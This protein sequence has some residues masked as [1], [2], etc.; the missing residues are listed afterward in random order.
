MHQ[1]VGGH[2][3]PLQKIGQSPFYLISRDLLPR[4]ETRKRAGSRAKNRAWA[5]SRTRTRT[6]SGPRRGRNSRLGFGRILRI[7]WFRPA[8]FRFGRA[9]KWDRRGRGW[10]CGDSGLCDRRDRCRWGRSG[11][12]LDGQSMGRDDFL[13]RSRCRGRTSPRW[14]LRWLHALDI[15]NRFHGH[16]S[17]HQDNDSDRKR[18]ERPAAAALPSNHDGTARR[19]RGIILKISVT[20]DRHVFR[21]FKRFGVRTHIH[22]EKFSVDEQKSFCVSE[23]G[24]LGEILVFDFLKTAGTDLGHA[25]GL[26]EREISREACF[27]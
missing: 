10:G 13:R 4:G 11:R 5:N 27:L 12:V 16:E 22:V 26:I 6:S 1:P 24:E 19:R 23:A 14:C 7:H 21:S 17:A 15:E 18:K 3:P 2:R 8:H 9:G 25:A 20:I